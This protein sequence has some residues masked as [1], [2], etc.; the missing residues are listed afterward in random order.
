MKMKFSVKEPPL[1]LSLEANNLL[2]RKANY[3]LLQ[4]AHFQKGDNTTLMALPQKKL[5][6]ILPTYDHI[7]S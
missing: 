3:F 4:W 6:Q 5:Y 2:P 7:C 1:N